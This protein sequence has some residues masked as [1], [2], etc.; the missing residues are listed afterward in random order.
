MLVVRPATAS[1]LLLFALATGCGG[2][3]KPAQKTAGATRRQQSAPEPRHFA[4]RRIGTLPAPLQDAA[5]AAIDG[6]RAL[7]LGGL[8]AED[9]STA[10]VRLSQ[11]TAP[12]ASA[13]SAV[14]STT[15]RR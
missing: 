15:R 10:A 6:R 12:A 7:L 11:V 8:D 1:A 5:A 3:G 14:L 4:L 13:S 9:S 2:H